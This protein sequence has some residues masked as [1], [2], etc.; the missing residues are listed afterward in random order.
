VRYVAIGD[1]FTEGV[2]DVRPDGSVRGWADLVAEGMARAAGGPIDYANLA[3]RGRKLGAILDEQL[4]A[5]LALDPAPTMITLNGG[6]NDMLRP[7]MDAARLVALTELAVR[8]C[9]DE[10]IR[11]VLLSGADPSDH[12]PFGATLRTRGLELTDAIHALGERYGLTVVSAFDD[13]EVRRRPYWSEDRLHLNSDGHRRVSTLVLRGLG[14]DVEEHRLPPDA[15]A[16]EA[17]RAAE[18][19]YYARHVAPW[20]GRRLRGRSSGDGRTGKH[21]TWTQVP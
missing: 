5:A 11:L 3:V 20:V 4:P 2:G 18:A 10:G 16:D 6:G 1:S 15:A 7:G 12:L 14:Y 17:G 13:E 8:R 21:L 9:R 19:R